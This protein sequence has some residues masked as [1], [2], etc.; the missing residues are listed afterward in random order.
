MTF[1]DE[2]EVDDER[3][4]PM[5]ERAHG[6]FF[7]AVVSVERV[8]VRSERALVTLSAVAIYPDGFELHVLTTVR[9]QRSRGP[10]NVIRVR[11]VV[12]DRPAD[13]TFAW[14]EPQFADTDDPGSL[15]L[16][17][18]FLIGVGLA[19]GTRLTAR[20]RFGVGE[21][22]PTA[23]LERVP[24]CPSHHNAARWFFIWPF[25]EGDTIE[26]VVAWPLLDVPE[27]A[28]TFDLAPWRT[29]RARVQPVFADRDREPSHPHYSLLVWRW[30]QEDD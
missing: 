26:V 14:P 21:R 11:E 13:M 30:A 22:Q 24:W 12:E 23:G 15:T 1:F 6:T 28:T 27:T 25:P 5:P 7:P 19:N 8:L 2:P 29:A 4:D 10:T 20:P 16:E 9:S 18:D 3:D 17:N